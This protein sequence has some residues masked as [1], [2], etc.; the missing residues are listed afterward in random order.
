MRPINQ[1][2]LNFKHHLENE[3]K[4]PLNAAKTCWLEWCD[5]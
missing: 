5:F 1:Y 3:K 4:K 2:A